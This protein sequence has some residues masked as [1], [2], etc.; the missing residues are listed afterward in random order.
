MKILLA[1]T[2]IEDDHRSE[3]VHDS[4][5]PLGLAYLQ[6]YIEKHRPAKDEFRN[7]YLNNV[8]YQDCYASI[9]KNLREMQPDLFGVSI[10]THSRVSAYKMIE[11][12]HEKYPDMRIMVGGMHPT[13][14]W[15]QF[16]EKYPYVIVCRGEGERTFNRVLQALD[17]EDPSGELFSEI[18][19]LA[20][21]D[22]E[23]VQT[24][25]TAELIPDLDELPFPKH[26]LF[27]T[28]GK[29]MANLL[30]S[31]G[32]PYRCN[33]CVL[34]WMS[35]RKVRFRSGEN[36]ADE[37]EMIL[38]KYP[39][40]TT[41]WIHDDAFMINKDRTIEF[42]D[43]IIE[44]GIKTQFV[45]SARFRPISAEVV[46]KM[47]EAGF[48]HVLFGLESGADSVMAGMKKGI[49]KEH[50]RYGLELFGETGMKATAFLIAGLPGETDETIEE[51]IDFVQELQNINYL[52]YEDIGVAMIYP[53]TLM[54]AQALAD[55]KISDDYWLTDANVPYY[56]D[57]FGGVHTYEKLEEMKER[58]RQVISL[59]NISAPEGFLRQ[60]KLIPSILKYSQRFGITPIN[61]M[62]VSAIN[63]NPSLHSHLLSGFFLGA[64]D[65]A[66]AGVSHAFEMEVVN[67]ILEHWLKTDK[68]KSDFIKK[69]EKQ[70]DK[71]IATLH[72]YSVNREE[73]RA[74]L[75]NIEDAGDVAYIKKSSKKNT[76]KKLD[77]EVST[78]GGV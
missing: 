52:Y 1:C 63:R 62:L 72:R 34:D 5:Y 45:A 7:L 71:D 48:V 67:I 41:I 24:S 22:G 39:S 60:R 57:E 37:V 70:R 36:I 4:H 25:G 40:I 46:R 23:K 17:K 6:S 44:R 78:L 21:H 33:F 51:T 66:M 32:C 11:Y 73:T 56:T 58:I 3:N 16:A 38:E 9:K 19:G 12:A 59:Q 76:P 28:E 54:Y 68:E 31:R 50:V 29:T 15:K 74:R 55:G 49:K 13:V 69:Y 18:P 30:T 77:F 42:C 61:T 65:N 35:K 43:A 8:N 10:M 64:S 53:G 75:A 2:S 47:E 27:V 14:M 20:W 26:E